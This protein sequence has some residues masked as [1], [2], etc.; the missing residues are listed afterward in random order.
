MRIIT[1]DERQFDNFASKHKYRNYYQTSN[2]GNLMSKND[3]KIQYIGITDDTGNLIGASLVLYKEIFMGQKYAYM[4][5]GPLFDFTNLEN[6]KIFIDRLKKLL[7]KQGFMYVKIDP[8][9]PLNIRDNKG[10]LIKS[11]NEGQSS[12]DN[13]IKLAFNHSGY[14][15]FFENEKSR[16]EAI[17]LCRGDSEEAY[18]SLDKNVRNK[19]QKALKGGLSIVKDDVSNID[20]LY[21]FV[22]NKHSRSLSYYH[23]LINTFG[24]D[25]EVYYANMD[26]EK[27]VLNSKKAYDEALDENHLLADKMHNAISRN[28]NSDKILNMKMESDRLL[29]SY[30]YNLV[31]AT[32]LL[33]E[34]PDG[35]TIAGMLIIKYDNAIYLIIEGNDGEHKHLNPNYLLKWHIL[36]TYG[37]LGYKYFNLNAIVGD[38]NNTT[39]FTGLN[40]MKLG[41]SALAIEYI[42]EFELIINPFFYNLYNKT[43]KK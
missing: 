2:Y 14:N 17:A 7:S 39:S 15:L 32:K 11:N 21:T 8:Y 22:K 29:H 13:L 9:I 24:D 30:K 36:E 27:F 5:R 19:I 6:S 41:Y 40:E 42:G 25:A 37:K 33:K 1:L 20:K 3:M 12:V 38:F 16:W 10:V 35:I 31:L 43:K 26:T 18:R 23:G 4:P 28:E 34:N